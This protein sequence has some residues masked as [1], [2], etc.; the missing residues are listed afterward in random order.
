MK[1]AITAIERV[2][3]IKC[4]KP[5]L[6]KCLEFCVEN[7]LNDLCKGVLYKRIN[8]LYKWRSLLP[9]NGDT[10]KIT[11]LPNNRGRCIWSALQ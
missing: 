4:R 10:I 6:L 3:S 9:K 2:Y 11:W 1:T 7:I 8:E 5:R